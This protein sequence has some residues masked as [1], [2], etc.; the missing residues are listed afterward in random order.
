VATWKNPFG[1][2]APVA[3]SEFDQP[4]SLSFSGVADKQ[5]TGQQSVNSALPSDPFLWTSLP[6]TVTVLPPGPNGFYED[7]WAPLGGKYDFTGKSSKGGYTIPDWGWG[8]FEPSPPSSPPPPPPSAQTNTLSST[9]G[10]DSGLTT[11][12]SSGAA[13]R[14][15][16]GLLSGTRD[17]DVEVSIYDNDELLSRSSEGGSGWT[18]SGSNWSYSTPTL[19]DGAHVLK[20]MF[21]R[22]GA[23]SIESSVS[24]NVDTQVTGSLASTA[25]TDTGSQTSVGEGGSTTDHTLGLS[26]TAE[27]GSTVEILDNGTVLGSATLVDGQWSYTTPSLDDGAHALT[28]R[29]TDAV[30][31]VLTTEALNVTLVQPPPAFNIEID[32]TGAPTYLTYFQQAAKRWSSIITADLPDYDGVDDLRITASVS[33]ID[34]PGNI[35]GEA[36][37]TDFRPDSALPYQG[38]MNFDSSDVASLVALNNFDDVVL[39]EMGHLLG[40]TGT[41]FQY[42][43]L[44]DPS[45]VY[46]YTGTHALAE[47]RKL[48][49]ATAN[50]SYVPLETGGGPGTAGSHWSEKV[51]GNELMTGYLNSGVDNLLSSVTVGALADLGYS[52]DYSKADAYSLPTPKSI[53]P[54]L[55]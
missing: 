52:V 14:D 9:I 51:F 3:G 47:Y 7:P 49:P 40:L 30:G 37:P 29:V 45:N 32:Y 2:F 13:T 19:S 33:Y 27:A 21:T 36:R 46:H 6:F 44:V 15:N 43:G 24:V 20:V 50:A 48:S 12:V 11:S 41:L 25:L 42:L 35:L 39:H 23:G 53:A 18:L 10:T 28:A 54:V 26:G 17:A 16:T 4:F 55:G 38:I 1:E 22:A 31:N 8:T 34:G 5:S